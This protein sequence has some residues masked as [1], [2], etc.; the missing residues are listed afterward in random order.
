MILVGNQSVGKSSL[1]HRIVSSNFDPNF[2]STIGV[3]FKIVVVPL[4][5]KQIALQIWDTAGQE[6]FKALTQSYFKGAQ[7]CICVYDLSEP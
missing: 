4:G 2:T 1:L 6:K 3:D 7:A 5:V